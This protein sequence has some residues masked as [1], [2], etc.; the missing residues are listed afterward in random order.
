MLVSL[1]AEV[2]IFRGGASVSLRPLSITPTGAYYPGW[3]GNI[4]ANVNPGVS[5][6][7][8]WNSKSFNI[9]CNPA[10]SS[11][12]GNGYFNTAAFSQ[13]AFPNLGNGKRYYDN[14][15]G[16]GYSNE[17]IGIF[18]YFKV[19]ERLRF[20]LRAEMLNAFNR[21]HFADPNTNMT[22]PLFGLVSNLADIGTQNGAPPRAV[23]FGLRVNW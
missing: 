3:E 7:R 5:M 21:H 2:K 23:Q 1:A 4:Y 20:Q 11:C 10:Q 8:T 12:P 14:L 15:R 19:G 22:D 18:K 6:S 9:D 13:P 16:F 17:D